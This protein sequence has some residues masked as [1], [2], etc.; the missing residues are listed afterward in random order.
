MRLFP[1]ISVSDSSKFEAFENFNKNEMVLILCLIW[2][3][4]DDTLSCNIK[5]LDK[6]N[7][8]YISKRFILSKVHKIYDPVDFTS[9]IIL[10]TK[11]LLQKC[12]ELKVTWD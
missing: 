7:N 5:G 3:L 12:Q 9:A 11:L 4:C 6:S 8:K 1:K 10:I 2:N